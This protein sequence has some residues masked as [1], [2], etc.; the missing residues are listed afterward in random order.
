MREFIGAQGST[1]VDLAEL[2]PAHRPPPRE[3]LV[4]ALLEQNVAM[5][6]Q[7]AREGFAATLPEY[8]QADALRDQSVRVLGGGTGI[9]GGIARG[10]DDDGALLVEHEGRIHRIIAGEVSVRRDGER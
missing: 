3:V 1:P 5:L 10:V 2:S 7:F 4:A 8:R 9:A 6:Q